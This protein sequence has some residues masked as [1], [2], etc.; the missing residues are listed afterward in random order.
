[1]NVAGDEHSWAWDSLSYNGDNSRG[2][3]QYT[4]TQDRCLCK[5][6]KNIIANK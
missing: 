1:M 5:V 3:M 2:F 6:T 4:G